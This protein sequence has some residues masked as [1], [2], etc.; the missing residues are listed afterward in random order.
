MS[1]RLG[2]EGR[3][4]MSA[5]TVALAK[6]VD[7]AERERLLLEHLP[8]VQYVARRIHGRVPQQVLLL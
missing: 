1:L 2:N 3:Q 7:V 8:Q 5:A 6:Q 4:N